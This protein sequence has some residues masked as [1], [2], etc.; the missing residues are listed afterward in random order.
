[1]NPNTVIFICQN[2]LKPAGR[3]FTTSY[4]LSS[5]SIV[6]PR[7]AT[8]DELRL[9][10]SE[11]YLECLKRLSDEDDDEKHDEDAETYGLSA[12]VFVLADAKP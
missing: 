8:E 7:Q 10:H 6:T 4:V 2:T 11:D 12:F 1:M 3:I 5:F 9:F